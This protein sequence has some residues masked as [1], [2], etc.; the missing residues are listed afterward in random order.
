MSLPWALLRCHF[1][2]V[3]MTVELSYHT[4][5]IVGAVINII[6]VTSFAQFGWELKGAALA[7]M[8]RLW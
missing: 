4:L 5:M 3:T 2:C 1:Y 6:F 8:A 7:T